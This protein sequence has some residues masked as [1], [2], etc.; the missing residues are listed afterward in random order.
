M[1]VL[2]QPGA[3]ACRPERPAVPAD[4]ARRTL[5]D[6]AGRV[7]YAWSAMPASTDPTP[8]DAG[9]PLPADDPS[10]FDM[11]LRGLRARWA[12]RAALPP[13]SG[14]AMVG[15][16]AR[17]Q[18]LGP[19]TAEPYSRAVR[20]VVDDCDARIVPVRIR[21]PATGAHVPVVLFSHGL[22]GSVAAGTRW[23]AD[24]TNA[25]FAAIHLPRVRGR[26]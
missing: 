25:G 24:W 1:T 26:E 6:T 18:A 4:R 22:G 16:D 7:G 8:S 10:I 15:V 21:M 5:A 13:I 23:A 19:D 11:D 14:E 9:V 2:W 3:S 17:A 12:A 20:Y